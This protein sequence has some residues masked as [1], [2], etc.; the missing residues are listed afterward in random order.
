LAI[1]NARFKEQD[2]LFRRRFTFSIAEVHVAERFELN[3]AARENGDR[4][5]YLGKPTAECVAF[6]FGLAQQAAYAFSVCV[7]FFPCS[8]PGSIVFFEIVLVL[9]LRSLEP[10]AV[11]FLQTARIFLIYCPQRP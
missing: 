11:S 3:L 9:F 5:L 7:N 6:G 8:S 2:H 4:S 10:L 1:G